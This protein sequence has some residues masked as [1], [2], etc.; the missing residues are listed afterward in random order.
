MEHY[1]GSR[2]AGSFIELYPVGVVVIGHG[3][4]NYFQAFHPSLYMTSSVTD[5][6]LLEPQDNRTNKKR[7]NQQRQLGKARSAQGSAPTRHQLSVHSITPFRTTS[8]PIRLKDP[9]EQVLTDLA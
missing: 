1:N 2:E 5:V 6:S 8:S 7:R 4:L 3:T 9:P